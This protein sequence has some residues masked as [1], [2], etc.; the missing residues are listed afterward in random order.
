MSCCDLS[1]V[2]FYPNRSTSRRKTCAQRLHYVSC[3]S[4]RRKRR[5]ASPPRSNRV[6]QMNARARARRTRRSH[7]PGRVIKRRL[8]RSGL[9][10][11]CLDTCDRRRSRRDGKTM[12]PPRRG[13]SLIGNAAADVTCDSR[14]DVFSTSVLPPPH[15]SCSPSASGVLGIPS[16]GEL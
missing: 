14:F 5:A 12:P 8:A 9:S 7:S 6:M 15:V 10:S 3:P 13:H 4:A 11:C 1:L 16:R 2:S